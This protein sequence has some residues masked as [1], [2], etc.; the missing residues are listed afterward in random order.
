MIASVDCRALS[1]VARGRGANYLRSWLGRKISVRWRRSGDFDS[2]HDDLLAR[3]AELVAGH[4]AVHRFEQHLG[5]LRQRQ[6]L[7][8]HRLLIEFEGR[9]LLL[10][11]PYHNAILRKQA[12]LDTLVGDR[13]SVDSQ[14]GSDISAC[15]LINANPYYAADP[16]VVD[17]LLKEIPDAFIEVLKKDRGWL[18]LDAAFEGHRD[19]QFR[20]AV[21]E[22]MANRCGCAADRIVY[23][24]ENARLR[25]T[26]GSHYANRSLVDMALEAREQPEGALQPRDGAVEKRFV[27]LN[28]VPRPHRAAM[29]LKL[30]KADL[31]DQGIVSFNHPFE[32]SHGKLDSAGLRRFFPELGD[33]PY[34]RLYDSVA[35]SLPLEVDARGFAG[36]NNES[37]KT[38]VFKLPVELYQATLFSVV[39][40]TAFDQSVV[41]F[42]EKSLKPLLGFHPFL[43]LGAA[44][45]L[46]LLR[47]LGFE[48]FHPAIDESYDDI[49]SGVER[50]DCLVQEVKRLCALP[51]PDAEAWRSSLSGILEHNRRHFLGALPGVSRDMLSRVF[52]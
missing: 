45:T 51:A 52:D 10:F 31:L 49:E 1:A 4:I 40:E 9:R 7:R 48:T 42:T 6:L 25:D 8:D 15:W 29:L 35:R 28:H 47:E 46:R 50:I 11:G 26:A 21:S 13:K 43:V 24:T 38:M 17:R 19:D 12:L 37:Y 18:V 5:R 32:S 3:Y 16:A 30:A 22:W 20:Q 14:S 2:I 44:G 34:R 23:L 27:F 33:E 41:R 36:R 39:S